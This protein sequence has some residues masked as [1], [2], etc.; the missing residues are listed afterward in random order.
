M[1]IMNQQTGISLSKPNIFEP[2]KMPFWAFKKHSGRYQVENEL[3]ILRCSGSRF[4]QPIIIKDLQPGEI[5][6]SGSRS[7]RFMNGSTDRS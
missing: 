4:G 7:S 5:L 2:V 6:N 1:W 3:S